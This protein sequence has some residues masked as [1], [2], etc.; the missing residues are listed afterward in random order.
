MERVPDHGSVVKALRL[1]RVDLAAAMRKHG[2]GAAAGVVL[3]GI[4]R[5]IAEAKILQPAPLAER[6]ADLA[7]RCA[8]RADAIAASNVVEAVIRQCEAEADRRQNE[9]D[10]REVHGDREGM[11]REQGGVNG[12]LWAI[13]VL[14]ASI[15]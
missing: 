10:D 6:L 14:R 5:H 8:D 2:F 12:L 9:Y 7:E 11:A 1:L 13:E 3:A 15:A 4:D